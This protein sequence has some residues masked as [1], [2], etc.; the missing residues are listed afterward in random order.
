MQAYRYFAF[1]GD[2]MFEH[3]TSHTLDVDGSPVHYVRGGSG[4]A[5]LLLH[6]H[7]QTHVIWHKVAAQLA[8]HFTVIAADLRGYGDSGKPAGLPD[9][10]N[11]AKRTM[12]QDQIDLMATLGFK[13]FLLMGHDRGGRVAYRMALD[14]PDAILKLVLLDVAP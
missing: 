5:L 9:H 3:F 8:R 12:G 13:Q 1:A 7:P 6:G 4:P 10:S 2:S 14:H 11:Y